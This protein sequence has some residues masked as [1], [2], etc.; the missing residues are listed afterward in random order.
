MIFKPSSLANRLLLPAAFAALCF[1]A[2][3]SIR[4]ARAAH[5]TGFNTAEGYEQAVRLEPSNPHNWYLLGRFYQYDFEQSNS[6]AALHAF[7]VARSL[8]PISADTL[9]DLATNYDET[10][11][12]SEARAAYLEAKRVYPLSAEVFWRY[13][14]FLLRNNEISAAFPEIRRA[15]ELDP[16]RGAEAFSRCHRVVSDVNEILEQVIPPVLAIHL[17]VIFGLASEGQL[18]A[19]LQVWQRAKTLP[20][21][22]MLLDVYPLANG[23]VESLRTKEAVQF[24]QEATAKV[25]APIPPDPPGSIIWDGSFESGFFG[26]G[27]SWHFPPQKGVL[28]KLDTNE[29]HSGSQSLQVMF[30]G[31]SNVFFNQLCHWLPVEQNKTYLFSAWVKTKSLTSDEGIRFVIYSNFAGKMATSLT[32]EVHGDRPWTNLTLVWTAP[33]DT[34]AT[35]VCAVRSPSGQPNGE[36]AG[37]AWIDDVS[38]IPT[39][40]GSNR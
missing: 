31:R 13:G 15:V 36:I 10:G 11:K 28:I 19:A 22:L 23:L 16:K 39:D 5:A 29:K 25:A 24:W 38:M 3:F 30:T 7:L 34:A 26:A 4:V 32:D 14:N 1:L 37:L 17:D 27:Y 6:D 20:G 2:Y 18:D 9:L 8:D 12:I 35:Q 33:P 21:K 40:S